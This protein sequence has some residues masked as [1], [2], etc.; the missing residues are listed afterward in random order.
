MEIEGEKRLIRDTPTTSWSDLPLDLVILVFQRLSF[1]NFQRAKSVCSSWYSASRQSVPKNNQIH[2]L[3]LFP[4]EDNK[5]NNYSCT[6]FNPDEKD[7]HYKTQDLGVEFANRRYKVA[8]YGSWLLI[9]DTLK[10][11]YLVNLFTNERI[12]LPPVK[13]LREDYELHTTSR[14]KKWHNGR[15]RSVLSPV[16]WIDEDTKDYVVIWGF[17]MWCV[18]YAKKGDTS[19]NKIPDISQCYHMVYRD[20][21]LYFLNFNDVFKIFDLSGEIPQLTFQWMV[22]RN[23][24][25]S[26]RQPNWEWNSCITRLV[27]T[28]TGKVLKVEQ[29]WVMKS[30]TWSF[31][32]LEVYSPD[33]QKKQQRRIHYLRDES[34]LLDQ[35]ITVLA[36]DADGFARNTIYFSDDR[37]K[38]MFTFNLGTQKTEPLH[39]FDISSFQFSGAQWFLPSFTLT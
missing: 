7:K 12:N 8:T 30:S 6:L 22:S 16:F 19:W 24:C 32:V 25:E 21:K 5:D 1:A 34:I 11:M 20:H 31:R 18:V 35:G 13:L 33:L 3:I 36:N 14:E 23:K 39:T 28:L 37:Q 2:W 9:R 17:G 15:I 29:M 38:I 4:K 10:E 26:V 27:V